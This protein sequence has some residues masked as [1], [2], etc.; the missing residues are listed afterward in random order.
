LQKQ[1]KY[2]EERSVVEILSKVSSEMMMMTSLE[3]LLEEAGRITQ[4]I[5]K[6]NSSSVWTRSA[7]EGDSLTMTISSEVVSEIWVVGLALDFRVLPFQVVVWA[8][9]QVLRRPQL[10][11][12][13]KRLLVLRKQQ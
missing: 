1:T 8:L 13:E 11:K 12:M 6:G 2:L 9:A 3:T 4:T 7:W 10:S 5:V